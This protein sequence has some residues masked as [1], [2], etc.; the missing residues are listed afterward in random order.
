MSRLLDNLARPWLTQATVLTVTRIRDKARAQA[1][2]ADQR[3]GPGRRSEAVSRSEAGSESTVTLAGRP[4]TRPGL[5]RT[6][7][8]SSPLITLANADFP[9]DSRVPGRPAACQ[10]SHPPVNARF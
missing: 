8:C 4:K 3:K 5:T 7:C 1:S 9:F 6:T 10:F 2:P